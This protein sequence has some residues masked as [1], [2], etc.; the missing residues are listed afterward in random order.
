MSVG[1]LIKIIQISIVLIREIRLLQNQQKP[2]FIVP[3][4]SPLPYPKLITLEPEKASS[5]LEFQIQIEQLFHKNQLFNRISS[6]FKEN[7][8][9]DFG[10]LMTQAGIDHEFGWDFLVQMALHKRTTVPALTGMLKRHFQDDVQRT[11]NA[12]KAAV[13]ADMADWSPSH[14]QFII[15]WSI[16][17]DVQ[18]EIDR[19]QYPLPMVIPPRTLK[20]NHDTGYYTSHDSVIL[21]HN[22]HDEDVCL[23]HLNRINQIKYRINREVADNIKN[24]W[25]N[26][27]KPKPHE[28]LD[29]YHKRVKA[30][31]KFN[32]TAFDVLDHLGLA[33]EGEFWLTSKYDKRGRSYYQGYHVQPQGNPWQK[34]MVEFA[35]Q[36]V[37]E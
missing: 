35:N 18:E 32:R 26:L 20:T 22:H 17:P 34:A 19:Y 25:K 4:G 2:F 8:D 9:P 29:E 10:E 37:T 16:S 36:E 28:E 21:R 33:N 5:M 31:D 1:T 24:R 14:R 6:E 30:F 11:A 3:N 27:D 12:M 13:E 15:K 23:D 7:K